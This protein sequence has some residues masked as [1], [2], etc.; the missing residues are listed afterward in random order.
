MCLSTSHLWCDF[1]VKGA[2]VKCCSFPML[3]SLRAS[4]DWTH[5]CLNR[6]RHR[7]PNQP[8]NPLLGLPLCFYR[9]TWRIYCTTMP[10]GSR[11]NKRM[12][13]LLSLSKLDRIWKVGLSVCPDSG[14]SSFYSHLILMTLFCLQIIQIVASFLGPTFP[15][16][17]LT[18][19]VTLFQI[20]KF[21]FLL[22]LCY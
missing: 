2:S 16:C 8:C 9:S 21:N 1:S 3:S 12:S 11:N 17:C 14:C 4:F 20:Q 10:C 13:G 7:E 6:W 15:K 18:A 5:G 22:Q 19:H